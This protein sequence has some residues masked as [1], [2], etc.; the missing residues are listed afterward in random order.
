MKAKSSSQIERFPYPMFA[1]WQHI[2]KFV[3]VSELEKFLEPNCS[4]FVVECDLS[5]RVS[6]NVRNFGFFEKIDGF[7]EKKLDFF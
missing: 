4:N 7:F 6:Q 5:S 2:G 1:N 3:H